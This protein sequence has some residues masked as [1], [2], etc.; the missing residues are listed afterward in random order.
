MA[1]MLNEHGLVATLKEMPDTF[2][3]A[4]EPLCV[5]AVEL[6]H[7]AREVCFEGENEHVVVV[8]HQAVTEDS[9]PEPPC[10]PGEDLEESFVVM[11]ITEDELAFVPSRGDVVNAV[12]DL[13]PRWS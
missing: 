7:P 9:P 5:D 4:V 11:V 12:V 13:D 10:D 2:V 3:A 8:A 6:S 1:I